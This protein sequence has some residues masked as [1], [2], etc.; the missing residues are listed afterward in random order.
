M[1]ARQ[2]EPAVPCARAQ[3]AL[4]Q[5]FHLCCHLEG[6]Q[7]CRLRY[8]C[9]CPQDPWLAFSTSAHAGMFSMLWNRLFTS[10]GRQRRWGLFTTETAAANTCR[11]NAQ[12][13][14]EK[15]VSSPLSAASETVTTLPWPRRSFT[16]AALGAPSRQWNT[17][18]SNG[19]TGATTAVCL[20]LLGAFRRQK[21]R[22]I[23]TPLWKLRT[24]PRNELKSASGKPG[25]VH[26]SRREKAC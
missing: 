17:Q 13:G 18:H 5:R 9:L 21:Q 24:L 7:L 8:R 15:L 20:T 12:R 25:A 23:S 11:S 2:G 26:P 1:P 14:W 10:G 6:V 19:W 4:G 3:H 16:A 22:P